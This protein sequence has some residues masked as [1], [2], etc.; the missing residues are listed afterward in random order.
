MQREIRC[1]EGRVNTQEEQLLRE[2]QDELKA[3]TVVL[4]EMAATLKKLSDHS[5]RTSE[6]MGRRMKDTAS[7]LK[8]T[9]FEGMARN[10]M[11]AAKE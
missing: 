8:G 11:T 4:M 1:E 3:Q 2:I 6:E 10:L 5:S 7:L 9:P